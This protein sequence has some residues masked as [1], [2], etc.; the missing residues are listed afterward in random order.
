MTHAIQLEHLQL[1][2]VSAK[3]RR[4]T[5]G[6]TCLLAAVT[7]APLLRADCSNR[8]RLRMR[9]VAMRNSQCRAMVTPM[10]RGH[11]AELILRTRLHHGLAEVRKTWGAGMRALQSEPQ[12]VLN[13]GAA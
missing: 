9:E 7:A 2:L 1:V 12:H 8:N 13:G 3:L 5:K 11:L 4:Y 10:D 6:G